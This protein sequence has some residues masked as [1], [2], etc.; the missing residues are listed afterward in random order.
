MVK[1]L[2]PEKEQNPQ[3]KFS[4][5]AQE[6]ILKAG[7]EVF[8]QKGKAG[9]R[10]YEI[11]QRAG[12]NKALVHYYFSSKAQLYEQVFEYYLSQILSQIQE[13]VKKASKKDLQKKLE[14]LV[15]V[16]FD[17]IDAHPQIVRLLSW[18]LLEGAEVAKKVFQKIMKEDN[19]SLPQDLQELVK[20]GIKEKKIYP[21]EPPQA[22]LSILGMTL[23]YFFVRPIFIQ[24]WDIDLAQEEDFLKA[25]R[26]HIKSLLKR[27]LFRSSSTKKRRKK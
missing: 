12:V 1:N 8:S 21:V 5:S 11:A 27:G 25:R 2:K 9:A 15:D 13:L 18:E 23:F 24:I 3:N 20:Q 17:F 7:L 19:L 4:P 16:Y 14:T 26:A 6:R 10:V 22:V